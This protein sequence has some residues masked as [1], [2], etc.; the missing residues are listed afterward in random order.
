[1]GFFIDTFFFDCRFNS[2]G[3]NS[4][5][6]AYWFEDLVRLEES[7]G[8]KIVPMWTAARHSLPSGLAALENLKTRLW[9]RI[10]AL[11]HQSI[12]NTWGKLIPPPTRKR[13]NAI[14]S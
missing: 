2:L 11:D 13:E 10:I 3:V 12:W 6:D 1:M 7:I 5:E 8:E 14:V 4:I 9:N